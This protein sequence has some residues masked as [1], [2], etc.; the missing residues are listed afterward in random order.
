MLGTSVKT[1]NDVTF[2]RC[3]CMLGRASLLISFGAILFLTSAPVLAQISAATWHYNNALTS[4]NTS[5]SILTPA[6]VN[7]A[8]FGKLFTQPVDGFVAGQPL[9][10]PSVSIPGQGVHN[11]V[12]VA[13]MHDSVYAFD[14]DNGNAAPL[15]VTS[16]FSYSPAG[17]TSVPAT[18]KKDPGTTGWTELGIIST[19]VIDPVSDTLY[20]VAETYENLKVVHRLHALDVTTGQEKFGGPTTIAATYTLNGNTTTFADLYQMNR[21]GLLLANGHVYCA[22]GSNGNNNYSQGWVL[23][24]NA[25]TLQQEGTYTP[26]PGQTLASIWQKGAG[27][28]AD[29]SG[30]IYA[31][32][33]EGF[34]G[35]GTNLSISVLKLNQTGTTLAVADWFTPYNQQYLSSHDLDLN[36]GVLI[37]PDQPGSY[38]HELIAEG[39]EGTIYVLNRDNMGQF[40]STCT[41]GDT[42]IVQE[43]PQGAGKESG[44]PVYWNNTVYFTGQSSPVKAYTLSNGRLVVPPSVQSIQVGGGGHAII[45]ASGNSNGILWFMNGQSLWAMD[46]TTLKKL[47]TTNQNSRDFLP[48]LAHFVTPIVADGRVFIGTQNSLVV[49]GLLAGH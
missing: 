24:Y 12:Y 20:L 36:D 41:T 2:D 28:S 45:T 26:E 29:S 8:R 37:L 19:P 32:T 35:P 48:P 14:A 40:C 34:Y 16:I 30:N 25:A 6:N 22:W 5:E 15:W 47:Y 10:L 21:P 17:A 31:E 9:Y 7:V 13:T 18:V 43:I 3:G 33:A 42:Q 49:Y 46:A 1:W 23:S 44:T 4:A 11:V 27:L 39:K 38:P